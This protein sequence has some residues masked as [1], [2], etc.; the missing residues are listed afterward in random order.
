MEIP[1]D[2]NVLNLYDDSR[3]FFIGSLPP[4]KDWPEA[5]HEH[6]FVG[7]VD[8]LYL[9]GEA[10]GLWNNDKS[11]RVTGANMRSTTEDE[12][13][14]QG[15]S[16]NGKGYAQ[17][18]VGSW[19]PRMRTALLLSFSTYSP[20]GLLFFIGKVVRLL[21]LVDYFKIRMTTWL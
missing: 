13:S 18:D 1:G 5:I 16:L 20:D 8:A 15:L 2:K 3:H 11:V 6:T 4:E 12:R 9:N 17:I 10:I 14:E 7:D 19:N 21:G